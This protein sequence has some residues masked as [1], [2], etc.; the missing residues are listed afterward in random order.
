MWPE[1]GLDA[2]VFITTF[3][4]KIQKVQFRVATYLAS[5]GRINTFQR[6]IEI[7]VQMY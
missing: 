4:F 5:K 3:D 7:P 6:V 1:N 2:V